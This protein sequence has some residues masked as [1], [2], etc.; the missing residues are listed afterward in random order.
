MTGPANRVLIADN[1]ITNTTSHGIDLRNVV[2][3]AQVERNTVET[4]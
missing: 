3:P 1:R 2:G 4:V